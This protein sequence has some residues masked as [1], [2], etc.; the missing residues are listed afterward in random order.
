MIDDNQAVAT[1]EVS[2]GEGEQAEETISLSKS[3]YEKLNQT[4]GSLKRELKDYKKPKDEAKDTPQKNQPD[5]T[6]LLRLEK[7]A[8]KA[9]GVSH[10]D[11]V[12]LARKTARKWGMDVEDV[13]DDEDFKV[14]LERQQTSRANLNA[15]S[16]IKGDKS[17]GSSKESVEYWVAKGTPPSADQVPDR[18]SRAKIARAMMD[19]QKNSKKFYND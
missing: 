15:T 5:D 4:L 10:E 14:K 9:A 12:D 2:E 19:S 8:F 1:P 16:S 3:E 6:A 11:D 7:L 13:L 18:K 17:K